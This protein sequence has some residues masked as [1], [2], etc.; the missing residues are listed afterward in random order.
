MQTFTLTLLPNTLSLSLSHAIACVHG[1]LHAASTLT[2]LHS[3]TPVLP[4]RER[5]ALT[6][7]TVRG[8]ISHEA[9]KGGKERE[10]RAPFAR[11]VRSAAC[12][13]AASAHTSGHTRD[14]R[15]A[16]EQH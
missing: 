6:Q 16:R 8:L 7:H 11:F 10:T 5:D 3:L 4:A 13:C 1:C 15:R 14:I 2:C 9:L 12:A